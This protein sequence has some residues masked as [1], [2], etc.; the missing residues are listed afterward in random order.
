MNDDYQE[1]L[2]KYCEKH[3]ISP[4]EGEGH[5]IVRMYSEYCREKN[6]NRACRA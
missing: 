1:Y 2:K 6:E 4:E 5:Y 3:G